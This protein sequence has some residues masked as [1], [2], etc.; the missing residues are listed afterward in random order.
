MTRLRRPV[1]ALTLALL[2]FA[3]ATSAASA[4]EKRI[5]FARGRTSAVVRGMVYADERGG[6]D[7]VLRARSGQ[8]LVVNLTAAGDTVFAVQSPSGENMAGEGGKGRAEFRLTETG[9]YHVSVI[10]RDRKRV[11]F[12]LA[13]GVR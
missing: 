13:V 8:T 11:K 10:P 12:S 7:Y 1:A 6:G 4:A 2:A 3:L 5:R 9:D